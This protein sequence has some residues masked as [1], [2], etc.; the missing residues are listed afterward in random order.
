[1]PAITVRNVPE[2]VHDELVARAARKGKSLQEYLLAELERV[3][4][5]PDPD[6]WWDRVRSRAEAS[7]SQVTADDILGALR[8]VRSE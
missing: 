2:N 8:E 3:V 6:D 4:A 7:P 1:M 5:V